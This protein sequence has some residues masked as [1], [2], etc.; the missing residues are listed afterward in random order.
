MPVKQYMLFQWADY[1]NDS[2]FDGLESFDLKVDAIKAAQETSY[3]NTCI[4][5]RISGEFCGVNTNE[6]KEE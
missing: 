6:G 2:P 3:E 5:N 4:F 1:D